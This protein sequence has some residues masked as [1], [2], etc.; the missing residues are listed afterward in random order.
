MAKKALIVANLAGFASFLIHDMEILIEKGYTVTFAANAYKLEWADTKEKLKN[1]NIEFVQID[2]DSTNPIAKTNFKAYK[3]LKKLLKRSS[4]QLIH[5]HT[6]IAGLLTRLAAYPYRRKGTKV[7]Y[8][9]HGFTFTENSSK[10]TWA[11]FYTVEKLCSLL[12]DAIITINTEDYQNAKKMFC[13]KVF[14]IN[15][16]G[17]D[18]KRYANIAVNYEQYRKMIGVPSDKVMILSVGELSVRKNHQIVIKA[19][20]KLQNKN[21]YIFVICGNGIDGGTGKLLS[22]LALK[23]KVNLKLLGFRMDIPE[24]TAISDIGVIPS[25]REG[26]GLAGIQFLAAG[27]PVIGSNVQGIKDYI[28]DGK[29]GFLCDPFDEDAFAE[30]IQVLS[31]KQIRNSMKPFCCDMAEKFDNKVSFKQM[32]EVYDTLMI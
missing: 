9:T 14:R 26:L 28:I 12:C 22:D 24:I 2:F 20:A 19:I 31:N 25:I 23:E 6:P 15:G 29:D 30:K 16:V 18:T 1:L 17:V 3:Q 5:C 11:V 27:I 13:K 4:F 10:K 32:R 8:T 7:I 21:D